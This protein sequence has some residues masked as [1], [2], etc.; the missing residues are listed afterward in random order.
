[1]KPD[2][3]IYNATT[4]RAVIVGHSRAGQALLSEHYGVAGTHWIC[5]E[6]VSMTGTRKF[7]ELHTKVIAAHLMVR[8][9]QASERRLNELT[10]GQYAAFGSVPNST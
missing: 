7:Q 6:R 9:D 3:T 8:Y 2:I 10:E 5:I 4:S 1:M